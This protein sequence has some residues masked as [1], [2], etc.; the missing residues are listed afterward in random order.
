[1]IVDVLIRMAPTAIG[2]LMAKSTVT[3][4]LRWFGYR[5][6]RNLTA[7]TYDAAKAAAVRAAT[8]AP[9]GRAPDGTSYLERAV[10]LSLLLVIGFATTALFLV[11]LIVSRGMTGTD[12]VDGREPER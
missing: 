7:H 8:I 4:V 1:M 6:Q 2:S 9:N 5:D 12:H 11:V 10:Y 3:Q